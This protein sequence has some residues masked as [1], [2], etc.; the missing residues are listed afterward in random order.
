MKLITLTISIFLLSFLNVQA[1]HSESSEEEKEKEEVGEE[2]HHCLF[3]K[4]SVSIALGAPYSFLHKAVGINT[5]VYYNVGERI[6]FGPE[7]SYFK[8]GKFTALD[9]NF[10]GHYIFETKLVG[11][12]PLLG[13]NYTIEKDIHESEEAFGAVF[14]GGF[15]RNFGFISVF[16]E[17]AHVQSRLKDDFI[18]V[19]IMFNLR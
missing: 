16:A 19:G 1:Q 15:H 14:G 12:Y 6:C 5:R 11:L 9:F 7:F 3:K 13:V 4:N 17:Y 2:R 10:I 8:K 18:N